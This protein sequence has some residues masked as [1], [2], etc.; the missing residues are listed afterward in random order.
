[1][2]EEVWLVY[3]FLVHTMHDKVKGPWSQLTEQFTF[4]LVQDIW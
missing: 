3:S 4:V 2:H 1:M